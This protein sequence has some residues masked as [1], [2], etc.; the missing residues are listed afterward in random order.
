MKKLSGFLAVLMT[1]VTLSY[2][3]PSKAAIGLA[4]GNFPLAIRG[5]G[6]LAGAAL[7]GAFA[8]YVMRP[9]YNTIAGDSYGFVELGAG[10]LAIVG[11]VIL[12]GEGSQTVSLGPINDTMAK[13][14]GATAYEQSV[15]NNELDMANY[16][17]E[18]V[19][20]DLSKIK[21][22]TVKDSTKIWKGYESLVSP[23]TLS[24]MGKIS[25]KLQK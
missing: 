6:M 24:V 25:F 17:L 21:K 19:D 10:I 13:K 9:Q 20:H 22:P 5:A 2:S 12:D 11:I 23:E 8:E 3:Q 16:L 4:S 7:G 14:I 1:V 18:Q 15:F